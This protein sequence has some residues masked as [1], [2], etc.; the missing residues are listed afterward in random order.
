LGIL[1]RSCWRS[2]S[3]T[4]PTTGTSY[5]PWMGLF[6]VRILLRFPATV[7]SSLRFAWPRCE[8]MRE[9]SQGA[10]HVVVGFMSLRRYSGAPAELALGEIGPPKH[11]T[12]ALQRTAAPG[13][14]G[15]FGQFV[16]DS[17]NRPGVG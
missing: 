6:P 1:H 5:F 12:R 2:S 7:P 13:S 3:D 8:D 11:L 10:G 14:V 17:C 9:M 16:R 15:R 4:F